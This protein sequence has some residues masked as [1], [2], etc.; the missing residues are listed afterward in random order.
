MSV[1]QI[2]M[3]AVEGTA[4]HFDRPYGYRI[5]ATL[6]GRA[7]PG[8]RVTVPF[9][10]GNRTRRG[11]L[12]ELVQGE[13]PKAL[14]AVLDPEPLI[15]PG[16]LGLAA[17][18]K[19][20][21]FC[22]LYEALR[23]MLPPG[24]D[25]DIDTVYA[26]NPEMPADA[27]SLL[28]GDEKRMVTLLQKGALSRRRLLGALGLDDGCEIP[29]ELVGRGLL[30]AGEDVRDHSG[31]A[32]VRVV[33]LKAPKEEALALLDGGRLTPKQKN[34]LRALLD[35][36][37][38]TV[39]EIGYFSG[40]SASVIGALVKKGVFEYARRRVFR[41]P[42][43]TPAPGGEPKPE[44]SPAQRDAC[45][46]LWA[47]CR[48]G[49]AGATLLYGVTGSGKTLVFL[50]LI[51]HLRAEGKG[52]IVLVPEISLT[53]QTVARFTGR[54]GADVA[55]LHSGL[56]T[57]ERFDEW[58][59][60]R[61]GGAHI[62]VGTRSAVFAPVHDL[63]L[64]I[65]DEE[66]E[67]TYKSESSP[68][69]HARDVARYRCA[70]SGAQLLLAS[71]TPCVETFF[72]ANS[73]RYA[74]IRLD[75]R[76]GDAQLPQVITVDMKRELAAGN[77]TP[78]SRLLL[79]ELQRNI[80]R[81]EQSIL[82]LNRRGY[83]TFAYCA[84]CGRVMTCPN[85]SIALTYHDDNERLMCHYCG[86]SENAAHTCPACGSRHMRYSGSGTQR[87][88]DTLAKL[89]PQARILRMDTDTTSAR[90]S[91]EK[92]LRRFAQEK[93]DILIGTQMVAKGLD[94]PNVTLAG[95]LSADQTLYMD[96]FRAGERTFSLLTQVIGRSGRGRLS[97]RAIIQTGTP[98]NEVIRLASQQ[99]YDAFYASEIG[100]RR[101]LLYPP[102]CD[103]CEIGFSG[104]DEEKVRDLARR[105]YGR[106]KEE[107]LRR[108]EMPIRLMLPS[109]ASICRLGGRTRYKI[110]FKCKNDR[111]LRTLVSGLLCEFGAD[112]A[113][114][115]CVVFA[116]INPLSVL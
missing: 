66:Q 94:F 61:G 68:R 36:G 60:V 102:F 112:R 110:L 64:I 73:G 37:E 46:R 31:G 71:A 20:Q 77:N 62:V 80:E 103:I 16:M 78:V 5:P 2:A 13:A 88:E 33:R 14:M 79:R 34:A 51:E 8:A 45:E 17:W 101:T 55:V 96:D 24:L 4:Y 89:L 35:A 28:D 92:I 108:P 111:N 50:E 27:Y 40:A 11:I 41:R 86:H 15:Q 93:Y 49:E 76:Y 72:A 109:P 107:A 10:R 7:L 22:T 48:S 114:R 85:C 32:S 29:G 83:N 116:D 42:V 67:H 59:R 74:L 100:L 105:F 19:A 23:L 87:A 63:G 53:P 57:G 82:L 75:E 6:A 26:L 56:S 99:D 91:H 98:E 106:L 12:L 44:L 81:G 70:R 21:T 113:N 69:Y 54:F 18:I 39:K 90:F 104:P 115:S 58:Q 65:I 3:V 9:G 38:A 84:D 30:L 43:P 52:V 97:G 1:L 47:R 25:A 95:I